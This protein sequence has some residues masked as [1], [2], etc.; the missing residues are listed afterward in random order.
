MNTHVAP[1]SQTNVV[2]KFLALCIL[3]SGYWAQHESPCH[4][5]EL[6]SRLGLCV[7]VFRVWESRKAVVGLYFL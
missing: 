3:F 6:S 1:G 2:F 7:F 4:K 5:P